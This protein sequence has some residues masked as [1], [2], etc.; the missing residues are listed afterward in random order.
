[1]KIYQVF[2]SYPL[3]YQPY[4]PPVIDKLQEV[5]GMDVQTIAFRGKKGK[6]E[7]VDILPE[8]KRGK[9]I[10]KIWGSINR[11]Y[12]NLNYFEIKSLR[13]KVAIIHI[14]HSFLFPKII[15]LLKFPKEKRPRIII[16]LRGGDTYIKPWINIKWEEFY[17]KYGEK[18]D[19]FIVMSENQ[20]SYLSRWGVPLE[21]IHVIPIS[22]GNR[23]K[24]EPK[25]PNKDKLK[26]VSIFRMR[27]EK[28]IADT[29]RFVRE[30]QDRNIPV[31]Y[32]IFGDGPDLGQ[33]YYLRDKLK[34]KDIVSIHGKI[35]N[36]K[37]KSKLDTYDF[38]LQLSFSES[39]GMS[40][41]EG[42]SYGIPAIVSKNGG[43]PEI[44]NDTKNGIHVNLDDFESSLNEVISVWKNPKKYHDMSKNA[45]VNSH[46]K[47]SL[48]NEIDALHKLY[49]KLIS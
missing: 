23:F 26:L 12:N 14:Q 6:K 37:L 33:V 2:E 11:N 49:T 9:I 43:L 22:F 45:I 18:I 30:L 32:D 28:N 29:L 1:M 13:E 46:Q 16:T 34:L 10:A 3:F 25:S 19:A 4:I 7:D 48:E 38:V 41:I 42:Q 5:K 31:E 8:Y 44:I 27:W 21:N 17:K 47:F 15:N 35:S 40:V 36:D 20:K 39:L 24:V